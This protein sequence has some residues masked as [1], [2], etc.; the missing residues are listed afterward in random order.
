MS[1]TGKTAIVT[2]GSRGIGR[3][4]C[5]ALTR[6]DAQVVIAYAT[7]DEQAL[8][9]QEACPGAEIF[10]GDVSDAAVCAELFSF[11][12]EKLAP[13][14]I[15][16]NN[17]GIIRDGYILRMSDEDF[18][19]VIDVN[20]KGAFHCTKLAAKAMMKKRSGCIVNISS[21]IGQAGNA[22][23]A[24]YAASKAGLIGLTK[25]T[26]LELASRGI[27]VNAVAPGYITTDMT[28]PLADEI[29]EAIRT[30]I[31]LARFGAPE[32]VA[33]AVAF[34]CSPAAGYITGQVIAVNGGMYM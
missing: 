8:A 20:L 18:A 5:E 23:Q 9:A 3:A 25:S 7:H 30:K 2:G 24:N 11:C 13:P 32:D 16:V 21:V 10:R 12:E 28:A 27:T 19:H 22:G 26:A 1:L 6:L 29:K 17:A 4:I 14:D 34:L 15:L 33:A 31:P